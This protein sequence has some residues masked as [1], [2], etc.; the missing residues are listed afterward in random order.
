MVRI[1]EMS[2]ASTDE[3]LT[4]GKG[5]E[6]FD[7]AMKICRATAHAPLRGSLERRKRSRG[8]GDGAGVGEGVKSE[9]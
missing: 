3:T 6:D 8:R 2:R 7:T 1:G 9:Q 4:A 5:F